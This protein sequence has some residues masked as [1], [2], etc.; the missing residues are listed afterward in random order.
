MNLFFVW[1]LVLT[2]SGNCINVQFKALGLT[3]T[4]CVYHNVYYYKVFGH[5]DNDIA[6]TIMVTMLPVAYTNFYIL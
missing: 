5:D 4:P 1:L 6:M 2:K 3:G